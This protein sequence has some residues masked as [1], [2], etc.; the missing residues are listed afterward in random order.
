[1]ATKFS[2]FTAQAATG[3]TFV[4]GYDGTTNA[5]YSQDNMTNFVLNGDLTANA[6]VGLATYNLG[7]TN[8]KV[9]VGLASPLYTFETR[10][11]VA[12]DWVARIMNESNTGYGLLVRANNPSSNITFATHNGNGYTTAFH[13]TGRV[14]I[15]IASNA[16]SAKF[17]IKG[18]GTTA[19][20]TALLVQNSSGVDSVKVIDDGKIKLG[21]TTGSNNLL[22]QEPLQINSASGSITN[23]I[24][25]SGG[26][27]R[28]LNFTGGE[29]YMT[30][31]GTAAANVT[32]GTGQVL[33]SS[34]SGVHY[35]YGGSAS[36]PAFSGLSV[37]D[38]SASSAY[39][40][41][42]FQNARIDSTRITDKITNNGVGAA[43]GGLQVFNTTTK[44][45]QYWDESAWVELG[46]GDNIYT[47]DGTIG[48]A[49]GSDIRTV[50]IGGTTQANS[51]HIVLQPPNPA[52]WGN[53]TGPLLVKG[54]ANDVAGF[55]VYNSA[56]Q[57]SGYSIR[58]LT[59]ANYS[60]LG[61]TLTQAGTINQQGKW[62]INGD[63]GLGRAYATGVKLYVQ[64]DGATSST[65]SLLLENSN[66]GYMMSVK[67]DGQITIGSGA[68]IQSNSNPQYSVVMGY[69]AK[70]IA[71]VGNAAES[72][73]IGRL[74]AG[75]GGSVAIGGQAKG[76]GSSS[77]AVGAL[78]GYRWSSKRIRIFISR[79]RCSSSS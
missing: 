45:L 31:S 24:R 46:G 4:V 57:I 21:N 8:G 75:N 12:N 40:A 59:N 3:T 1:M 79:C 5:Q 52:N 10:A 60:D 53:K 63:M 78:C 73:A 7:F 71:S 44:K 6:N 47:A 36:A 64:G 55:G 22:N 61:K 20:T 34:T 23:Y 28:I 29:P 37:S 43:S 9:G 50:T 15:G 16:P 39:P 58:F 56:A 32:F 66:G 74:A 30:V 49:A 18:E 76:L 51:N 62:T 72:V 41:K 77:V 11:T 26:T 54:N 17:Q 27:W 69:G 38:N 25:K 68:T 65:R 19:T 2:D 13:N 67:D 14:G 35:K 42:A 48:N 33:I 70:D